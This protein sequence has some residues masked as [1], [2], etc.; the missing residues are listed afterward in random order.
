MI[1]DSKLWAD[2]S[3]LQDLRPGTLI[4]VQPSMGRLQCGLTVQAVTDDSVIVTDG[5]GSRPVRIFK[6]QLLAIQLHEME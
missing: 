1:D 5:D 6:F 2:V 4:D 3:A